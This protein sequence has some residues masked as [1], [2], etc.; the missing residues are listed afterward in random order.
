MPASFSAVERKMPNGQLE[1]LAAATET[2]AR[3][4][5]VK[6]DLGDKGKT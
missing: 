1:R 6:V 3:H 5:G 4:V 2:I